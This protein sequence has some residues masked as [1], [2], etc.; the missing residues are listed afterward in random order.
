MKFSGRVRKMKGRGDILGKPG[1][2]LT[3]LFVLRNFYIFAPAKWMMIMQ[4]NDEKILRTFKENKKRGM[5]MLFER[6][7]RPLVVFAGDLLQDNME[8]EDVVQD[9]FLRLWEDDYMLTI[10]VD[11]LHSYLF[12][13]VRNRCYTCLHKNDV[14]RH[15][16]DILDVDI[17]SDSAA[18]LSEEIVNRVTAEINKLPQQTARVLS[19]ILMQDMKY[20]EAAD[21]LNVSV[22]TV[23]TLLRNGMRAL[24]EA[25][26]DQRDLILLRVFWYSSSLFAGTGKLR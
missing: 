16:V 17:A 3:M 14:L 25:M 22:N 18:S 24:C 12:V 6:Y 10:R 4:A 1:K 13:S 7:Y 21:H 8:A 26:K 23:K 19:C 2:T 20:Q 15:R 9:F 5:Q 11:T